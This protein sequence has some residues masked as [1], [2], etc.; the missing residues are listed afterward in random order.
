MSR[1][2]AE[3]LHADQ[4]API[5]VQ[6]AGMLGHDLKLCHPILAAE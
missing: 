5:A 3:I 6:T 2:F 1:T 4:G